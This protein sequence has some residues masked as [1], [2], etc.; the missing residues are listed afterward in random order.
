MGISVVEAD[1][2]MG[3][4]LLDVEDLSKADRL[5]VRELGGTECDEKTSEDV[6]AS[7]MRKVETFESSIDVEAMKYL[8]TYYDGRMDNFE[9]SM[10]PFLKLRPKL[11]K[12]KNEELK[13]RDES[14]LKYRPVVD[15]SRCHLN[16]Y[17]KSLTDYLRDLIRKVGRKHFKDNNPM[18][19]NGQEVV[20]VLKTVGEPCNLERYF[21]V[22]DLSSA[23]TFIFL[24][25]LLIAMKY[26]GE[27]LDIPVWK[28]EAFEEIANLVFQNSYLE[29]SE[30]IF[31]L[32]TC[33]PMGLNCSGEAMDVVLLMAELVFL[34]KMEINLIEFEHQYEEYKHVEEKSRSLFFS[35][36]RYRDDTFSVVKQKEDS[37]IKTVLEILGKAF[38][39][40]LQIN[41][42]ISSLVGSFL[43][44]VFWK[45]MS[46]VGFETTVRR[47]GAYPISYCH[48]SSNVPP[49]ILKSILGGELLRHRRITGNKN[50]QQVN[51]ECIIAELISRGYRETVVRK[52][53]E[54]RIKQ[55]GEEYNEKL[56]RRETKK[57]PVGLVYGATTEYDQEWNTHHKLGMILKQSLPDGVR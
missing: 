6:T 20:N 19:K 18:I 56:L 4:V 11:H 55:I 25:N 44:V 13:E 9:E 23:Y 22:A 28:R 43:D 31:L 52:C 17:S 30:G 47:K 37:S 3:I 46:G 34:G 26:I 5:M 49:A 8:N 7:I 36:K 42:E 54:S 10:I 50:L 38:L 15:A 51:D 33:L 41:M 35:Y 24:E 2:G 40:S 32:G 48:G 21:V 39:P 14:K 53:V 45:R 12:M 57:R 16:G 27:D 1:K 29:T